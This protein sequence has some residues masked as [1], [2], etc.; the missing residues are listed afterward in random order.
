MPGEIEDPF[1]EREG[2]NSPEHLRGKKQRA[3]WK[4][5]LRFRDATPLALAL[6]KEIHKDDVNEDSNMLFLLIEEMEFMSE[7]EKR[8]AERGALL[9]LLDRKGDEYSN[10]WISHLSGTK[11]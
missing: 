4:E 3:M 10:C 6:E 11:E 8:Y 2:S 7:E 1:L 9:F 5:K